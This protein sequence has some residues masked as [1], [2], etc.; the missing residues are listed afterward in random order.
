MY[1]NSWD[2][3][4][5]R[6]ILRDFAALDLGRLDAHPTNICSSVKNAPTNA[7]SGGNWWTRTDVLFDLGRTAA[8]VPWMQ[9][10]TKLSCVPT[11]VNPEAH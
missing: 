1:N 2:E 3:C 7:V 8:L 11:H 10:P 4:Y 5:G 9:R 6:V